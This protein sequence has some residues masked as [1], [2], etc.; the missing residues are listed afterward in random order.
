M[1]HWEWFSK[2]K[3]CIV[4]SKRQ[5]ETI[6]QAN[7][8]F[9][10][11]VPRGQGHSSLIISHREKWATCYNQRL[12]RDFK[13]RNTF[14]TSAVHFDTHLPAVATVKTGEKSTKDMS[15]LYNCITAR[16]LPAELMWSSVRMNYSKCLWLACDK[17]LNIKHVEIRR[18]KTWIFVLGDKLSLP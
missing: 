8:I 11:N 13:P 17:E 10:Y 7:I 9:M 1:F 12:R 4:K 6:R 2:I 18:K 14:W 3:V 5:F 16:E 15:D